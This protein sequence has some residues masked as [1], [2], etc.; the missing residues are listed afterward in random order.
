IFRHEHGN[1]YID[2]NYVAVKPVLQRIK[3]I[4]KSVFAPGPGIAT[5]NISKYSHHGLRQEWKRPRRGTGDNR[6]IDRPHHG[7]TSPDDIAILR[8]GGGNSPEVIAVIGKL[9]GQLQA[10]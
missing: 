7:R 5:F 3:C 2:S 6:S 10:E 4:H 8:I 1:S 9:F